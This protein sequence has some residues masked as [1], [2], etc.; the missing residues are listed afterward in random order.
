MMIWAIAGLLGL[1]SGMRIG[2]SL[3]NEQS[4]V[5]TAMIL[6][7]GGLGAAAALH[8]PPLALLVDAVLGR[9][10]SAVV[11]SQVALI[12][13][14]AGSCV[15][16]T[17][18][19]SRRSSTTNGRLAAAHY[20]VAA[21]VAATGVSAFVL[22]GSAPSAASEDLLPPVTGPAGLLTLSYLVAALSLVAWG[23]LRHSNRSRRGRALF[24]F[25]AGI[26]L[27]LLVGAGLLIRV[28]IG[29]PSRLSGLD[30]TLLGAGMVVVAVGALL[31]GVEDWF[32][33]G[34]ELALI[35]PILDEL[36]R[37]HPAV[38]VAVRPRGPRVFRVAEKISLVSDALFLEATGAQDRATVAQHPPA[39]PEQQ[40]TEVARWVLRRRDFPGL[41]W[42]RQP[43][44]CSD[45][46][47]ILSIAQRYGDLSRD[48]AGV[49]G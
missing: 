31:P 13:A 43:A 45:R 44:T 49:S 10:H 29:G 21:V 47:W 4:V 12:A 6:S 28:A 5:N 25:T 32:A 2:W 22:S 15:M 41:G 1:V 7:L 48:R 19:T 20:A 46:E 38:R 23:G 24:V 9:P 42:M 27:M 3:A 16:I 35:T 40:A 33:A 8:W 18:V 26:S 17:S 14:A 36:G 11:G 37:R 39:T 34:R 30:A